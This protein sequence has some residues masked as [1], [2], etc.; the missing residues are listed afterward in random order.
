MI[1]V[2]SNHFK[3]VVVVLVLLVTACSDPALRMVE[4]SG[5]TMG[6]SYH[7]KLIGMPAGV[8]KE[9]LGGQ[10]NSLLDGINARMSTYDQ[11]SELFDF[12]A[13]DSTNWIDSSAELVSVVGEALHV[14][15]LTDGAFDVTVAPLVDLWGFGPAERQEQLPSPAEI[16][17]A[18]SRV[19]YTH[20]NVRDLPPSVRKDLPGLHIDLSAIAK[21][22]AVDRI[23]ELL[24]SLDIDNYLVEIG[25]ELRGRGYNNTGSQWRIG[26]EQPSFADRSVHTVIVIDDVGIAT[27]GD[28]RNYF[29]RDG[30]RYSHTIDPRSG[31]PI[32]HRLASV[33]VVDSSTAKAD[34]LATA[35]MV[36][37]PEEG[38]RLAEREDIAACFI[39][40]AND[41]FIERQTPSFDLLRADRNT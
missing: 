37:G 22:Y 41:G 19:G 38:Y 12:N 29:E 1:S 18:T 8:Q 2:R 6:T 9:S 27:S 3:L 11:Q 24:E 25:G 36:L 34:A 23:A 15:K 4:I 28:Y 21:G 17:A 33:T 35:L 16:A 39:I 14:S 30:V 7:V 32:D 26:I 5:M 20:L 13:S 10:I 40:R 31:R